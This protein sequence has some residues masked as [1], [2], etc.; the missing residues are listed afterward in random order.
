MTHDTVHSLAERMYAA[1]TGK[2]SASVREPRTVLIDGQPHEFLV[3]VC[4]PQPA[5]P[6]VTAQPKG[7]TPISPN[8]KN[9]GRTSHLA[10][11]GTWVRARIPEDS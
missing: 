2:A 9:P 11:D 6:D 3:L 10:W 4:P 7:G 5:P 8:F 1:L